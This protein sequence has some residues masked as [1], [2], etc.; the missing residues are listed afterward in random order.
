M[1]I[2]VSFAQLKYF[3]TTGNFIRRHQDYLRLEADFSEKR[4]RI[5]ALTTAMK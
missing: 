1:E 2:N 5:E 3:F 4:M